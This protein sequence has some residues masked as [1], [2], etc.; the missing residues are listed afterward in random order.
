M[1]LRIR[2]PEGWTMIASLGPAFL[3]GERLRRG[4]RPDLARAA[5]RWAY[6]QPIAQKL[7][8]LSD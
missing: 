4:G 7:T 5:L 8:E 3:G 6:H 2:T 1:G